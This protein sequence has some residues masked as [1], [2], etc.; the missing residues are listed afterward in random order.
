MNY[1]EYILLGIIV[2]IAVFVCFNELMEIQAIAVQDFTV[3]W[4]VLGN[5]I[6]FV[7]W[8]YLITKAKKSLK[9]QILITIAC[10]ILYMVILFII[11]S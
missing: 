11:C 6:L 3:I 10:M 2:L 4:F 8:K 5:I 7:I 1:F 9:K